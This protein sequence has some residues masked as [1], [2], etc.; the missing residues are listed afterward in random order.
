MFQMKTLL[1]AHRTCVSSDV[2]LVSK[3]HGRLI[4]M[5][6][7]THNLQ[8][9]WHQSANQCSSDFPDAQ[10]SSRQEAAVNFLG[11]QLTVRKCL[12]RQEHLDF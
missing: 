9:R 12:T 1:L 11:Y 8:R 6:L 3:V 10:L 7:L 5:R 4:L 2:Y